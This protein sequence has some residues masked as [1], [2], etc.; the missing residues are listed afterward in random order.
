MQQPQISQPQQSDNQQFYTSAP[1]S[2]PTLTASMSSSQ[3]TPTIATR[4]PPNNLSPHGSMP[5]SAPPSDPR[6]AMMNNIQRQQ[7]QQQ[8]QQPTPPSST[9]PPAM[10]PPESTN[11]VDPDAQRKEKEKVEYLLRTN[12]AL[13]EAANKLQKDGKGTDLEQLQAKGADG[14]IPESSR[15]FMQ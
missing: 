2:E 1:V 11:T 13:L 9:N 6:Q 14:G 8:A 3:N 7:Q 12:Q 15:D 10:K 5:T 4:T